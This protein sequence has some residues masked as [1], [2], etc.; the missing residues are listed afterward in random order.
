MKYFVSVTSLFLSACNLVSTDLSPA[1][2]ANTENPLPISTIKELPAK[3]SEVG[4]AGPC[5]SLSMRVH[6]NQ[7]TNECELF[8]WGGCEGNVPFDTLEECQSLCE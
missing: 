6:F 3:C 2:E 1:V 8:H 7:A 5:E 4:A